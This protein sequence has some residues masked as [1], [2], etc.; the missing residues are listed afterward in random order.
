MQKKILTFALGAALFGA[1]APAAV[2]ADWGSLPDWS[3]LWAL[4]PGKADPPVVYKTGVK[5]APLKDDPLKICGVHAG[6]P[7]QMAE[8]GAHEFILRPEGVRLTTETRDSVARVKTD[9]RGHAQGDDL[10]DT[11]TGDST[12]HWEGEGP[13]KTLVID[14]VGLRDDTWLNGRGT[15]HSNKAHVV[16]RIRKVGKQLVANITVDDPD[17]LAKPWSVTRT[18]ARMPAGSIAHDWACRLVKTTADTN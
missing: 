16:T 14:T 8:P 4:V 2:A 12:G 13:G 5:P 1:A 10:F 11:Y 18:Y 15:V 17:A 7:R 6:M 9:G 3:G